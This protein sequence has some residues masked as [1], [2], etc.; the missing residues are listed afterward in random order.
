MSLPRMTYPIDEMLPKSKLQ[1]WKRLLS[2]EE[3]EPK[4]FVMWRWL[5]IWMER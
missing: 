4:R 3:P 2:M 5:F 1:T